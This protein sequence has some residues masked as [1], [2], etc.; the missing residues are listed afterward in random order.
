MREQQV[1]PRE[2]IGGSPTMAN[3]YVSPT[4]SGD[5]SGSSWANAAAFSTINTMAKKAGD[6]GTVFLA[7][8][9]GTYVQ[10]RSVSITQVGVT[11]KGVNADGTAG[12]AVFEGSRAHDWI[13]GATTGNE[14]FRIGTGANNVTFQN[15]EVNNTGTAFRVTGDVKN[16]T[17]DNV[18]AHNVQ[19]YLNDY[20]SASSASITGLTITNATVEGFSKAAIAIDYDS[21]NVVIKDVVLDSK[22]QIG[23]SFAMGIHLDGTTHDVLIERVSALNS[24]STGKSSS[25]W[26]GDGFASEGSTYNVTFKDT[27]AAGNTDGGYDLKTDHLTL[28]NTISEGNGR[29]YRFWGTDVTVTDALGLDPHKQGGNGTQTQVWVAQGAEV[30]IVDSNFIDSGAGTKAFYNEG[31]TID[32]VNTSLQVASDAIAFFEKGFAGMKTIELTTVGS[33]GRFFGRQRPAAQPSGPGRTRGVA[34]AGTH[35]TG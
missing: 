12:S 33:T 9:Q 6:G 31:G 14:L 35:A 10:T 26:N 16:L 29:N 30:K 7:A 32:V 13:A 21:S 17:I 24:M 4:G 19:H 18:D 11:I 34:T 3:V 23:D 25:Y 28:I 27:Y 15:I 8:D 2:T 22:G 20:A 5:K 1:R